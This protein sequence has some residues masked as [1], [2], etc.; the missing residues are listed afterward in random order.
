MAAL[1]SA[2]GWSPPEAIL[3]LG[4]TGLLDIRQATDLMRS[5]RARSSASSSELKLSWTL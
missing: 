1:A 4:V 3:T 5:R 2:A